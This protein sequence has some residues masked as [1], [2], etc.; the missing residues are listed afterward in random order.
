MDRRLNADR[1]APVT[2]RRLPAL[3]SA[4]GTVAAG[5][6]GPKQQPRH[7]GRQLLPGCSLLFPLVAAVIPVQ[8]S[9]L[10]GVAS[11]TYV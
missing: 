10:E 5:H 7:L 4:A 3:S 6:R 8:P 2:L 11:V 1:S 9:L